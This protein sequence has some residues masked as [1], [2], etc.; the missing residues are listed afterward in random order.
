MI[1][2]ILKTPFWRLVFL[3]SYSILDLRLAGK[4]AIFFLGLSLQGEDGAGNLGK[5]HLGNVAGGHAQG[6]EGFRRVKIQHIPKILIL[7]GSGGVKTAANHEHIS[8]AVFQG[9]AV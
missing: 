1:P 2:F 4:C 7:K 6:V 5:A 3:F 8:N 9:L